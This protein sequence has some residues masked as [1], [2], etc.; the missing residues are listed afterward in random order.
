MNTSHVWLFIT[1]SQGNGILT[2]GLLLWSL[3]CIFIHITDSLNTLKSTTLSSNFQ[4]GE[5]EE[6]F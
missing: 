3:C 2:Y 4:K 6:G 1:Q 5:K